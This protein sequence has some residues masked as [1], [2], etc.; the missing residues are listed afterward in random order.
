VFGDILES[1]RSKTAFAED[2]ERGIYDLLGPL[3][4]KAAPAWFGGSGFGH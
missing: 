1:G 3:L 4:R 2:G